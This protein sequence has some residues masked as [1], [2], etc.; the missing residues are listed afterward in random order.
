M[1]ESSQPCPGALPDGALPDDPDLEWAEYCAWRDRNVAAGRHPDAGDREI[2]SALGEL[3]GLCDPNYADNPEW[4]S[5]LFGFGGP[6]EVLPPGP[7]LAVLAERA[8]GDL[9]QMSDA[10]LI[11]VLQAS[12]R[13]ENRESFRQVRLIAEFARRREAAFTDAQRRGVPAGLS[14]G[15]FPGE[16]LAAELVITRY[17]ASTHIEMAQHLLARLPATLAGMAAGQIDFARASA[18][19]AHT[20][21]LS[22]ADA[23]RADAVLAADAPDLRYDQLARKAAALE[24]KLDPGAVKARRERAKK[25]GQR[26]EARREYSGNASLSAREMDTAETMASKAYIDA[27]AVRLRN[28]GLGGSLGALR[29]AAM[30][31][32]TQGRNPLDRLKPAMPPAG[33]TAD[34]AAAQPQPQPHSHPQPQP[35]ANPSSPDSA[36]SSFSDSSSPDLPFA[37][38]AGP[39][40]WPGWDPGEAETVGREDLLADELEDPARSA[41]VRPGNP[42]PPPAAINLIVPVGTLLGWGTAPAQAG[43]WGLLDHEETR[44]IV[45]AASRHPRTR[46]SV[47]LT[48]P[49][50]RAIAHGRARGQHPWTPHPGTPPPPAQPGDPSGTRDGPTPCDGPNLAQAADLHALLARLNPALMPIAS[51]SCDHAHAEDGYRPS[52]KLRDLIRARTA[53]CTAPACNAQAVYSD[54]DH[55]VPW[56]DGPTDQCNLGPKCR[57]HHRVKQAP[58]WTVEQTEPGVFRWTLPSG[59]AHITTPTVYEV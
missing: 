20:C 2:E 25:E 24:M 29:V 45:E 16:E 15:G 23:G 33:T 1:G 40:G 47:T 51:Q 52:S 37:G 38:Y 53:T 35:A 21:D 17:A 31:D 28:G 3:A 22:D 44:R 13:L 32:L 57:T 50:G 34:P 49:Q 6:A 48:D 7:A 39:D 19:V 5:G 4:T 9:D 56:P 30:A 41:P 26:V 36:D 55:T 18:I 27:M 58:D 54:I 10:E 59:R 42:V 43:S 12:R 46:W 11:G 14:P 8:S